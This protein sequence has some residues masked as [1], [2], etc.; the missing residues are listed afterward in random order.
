LAKGEQFSL[1]YYS[2]CPWQSATGTWKKVS[3]VDTDYLNAGEA[4]YELIVAKVSEELAGNV[5]EYDDAILYGKQFDQKKADYQ[6]TTPDESLFLESDSYSW[7]SV[8]G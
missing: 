6:M 4:E 2:D 5:K 1:V 7:G 8:N 3:T